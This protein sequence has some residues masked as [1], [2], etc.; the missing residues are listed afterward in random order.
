MDLSYARAVRGTR[1]SASPK[2][3]LFHAPPPPLLAS[4][5]WAG[6]RTSSSRRNIEKGDDRG[7]EMQVTSPDRLGG[8]ARLPFPE[9]RPPWFFAPPPPSPP[10]VTAQAPRNSEARVRDVQ[11]IG[12]GRVGTRYSRRMSTTRSKGRGPSLPVRQRPGKRLYTSPRTQKTDPATFAHHEHAPGTA[13]HEDEPRRA[14]GPLACSP[15]DIR[16][17]HK[18]P[19]PQEIT[20]VLAFGFSFS[21]GSPGNHSAARSRAQ[22]NQ[23][24]PPCKMVPKPCAAFC[25]TAF[26]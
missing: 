2:R 5:Q 13:H 26:D 18:N 7:L 15:F 14:G 19:V 17:R 22:S 4:L 12:G 1:P 23:N 9:S 10:W 20:P 25:C 24:P 3:G 16:S 21:S 11:E 8:A 6:G